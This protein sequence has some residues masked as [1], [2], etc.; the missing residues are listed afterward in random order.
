MNILLFVGGLLLLMLIFFDFFHTTLSG[1]GFWYISAG[2]N[3]F[4]SRIILQSRYKKL[5]EFSG[6]IHLL[7][8]ALVWLLVLI[9][10]TFLIFA[11]SERMVV[12]TET[13]IPANMAERFYYTSYVLSTLG[14]GDFKPGTDVARVITGLLS[15]SGFI[16]LTTA[17]TYLLS[18][19]NSVLEKKKLALTISTMGDGLGS[20]YDAL[21]REQGSGLG[22]IGSDLRQS[23]LR[24]SSNY[25]AF[26]IVD[27][28]LTKQKQRAAEV[29][30]ASLYEVLKVLKKEFPEGSTQ[31]AHINNNIVAIEGYVGKGLESPDDF[32]FDHEKLKELRRFW[33]SKGKSYDQDYE[34]DR[35]F[36][37]SLQ[38]AGWSWEEVYQEK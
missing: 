15:F 1:R 23:V 30:L 28:F 34:K 31:V 14:I 21:Q 38:S 10:G 5:F 29:Q 13:N 17:L 6:L 26:P 37:A 35:L 7:S 36:N 27:H 24:N 22:D 32:D 9:L 19:V 25:L 11:S 3:R 8:T 2:V 20:L 12:N 16:L 4:L 33:L 18:V